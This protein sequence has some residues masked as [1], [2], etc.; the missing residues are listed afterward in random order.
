MR[1]RHPDVAHERINGRIFCFFFCSCMFGNVVSLCYHGQSVHRTWTPRHINMPDL[2]SR[3]TTKYVPLLISINAGGLISTAAAR[4]LPLPWNEPKSIMNKKK[5]VGERCVDNGRCIH[6][7]ICPSRK[8]CGSF[9]CPGRAT[10]QQH[11]SKFKSTGP[12]I[13]KKCMDIDICL[14]P[15]ILAGVGEATMNNSIVTDKR[16]LY[17]D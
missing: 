17:V 1:D 15:Q 5:T 9:T 12:L 6:T 7:A 13:I 10:E 4:E 14:A 11:E 16:L 3:T 2:N 8:P